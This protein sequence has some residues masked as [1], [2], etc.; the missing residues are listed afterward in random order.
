MMK[1]QSDYPRDGKQKN[2]RV[3]LILFLLSILFITL[4]KIIP[5]SSA[6]F[7]TSGYSAAISA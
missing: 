1:L 6:S 4:V 5:D 7:I 2:R 3:V